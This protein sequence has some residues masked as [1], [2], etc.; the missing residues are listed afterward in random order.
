MTQ[1]CYNQL[2]IGLLTSEYKC[3]AWWMCSMEYKGA[4]FYGNLEYW[5]K[6]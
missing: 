4:H 3:G 5:E 2:F 6:Q 1:A